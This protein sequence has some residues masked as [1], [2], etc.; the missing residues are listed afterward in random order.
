MILW[1]QSLPQLT[2]APS[3]LALDEDDP[4]HYALFK[5]FKS[6]LHVN[7]RNRAFL[8]GLGLIKFFTRMDTGV[9]EKERYDLQK[10]LRRLLK[11]GAT[12]TEAR[13]FPEGCCIEGSGW[14]D[15]G[16]GAVW[17]EIS[18]VEHISMETP[19]PSSEGRLVQ[20]AASNGIYLHGESHFLF[21]SLILMRRL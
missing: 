14:G 11:M 5:L 20:R 9:L 18:L 7:H 6:L 2:G 13:G 1:N 3:N 19:A 8:G 16:G 10:L 15:F 4:A 21:F 12:T 17:D